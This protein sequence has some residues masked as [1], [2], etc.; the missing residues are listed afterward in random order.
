M[1]MNVPAKVTGKATI[2]SY[3]QICVSYQFLSLY[4]FIVLLRH[5]A[6]LFNEPP[7]RETHWNVKTR[8]Y[9]KSSSHNGR[10]ARLGVETRIFRS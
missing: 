5:L 6:M 3:I 7:K 1:S 8:N 9:V 2:C 4:K 10:L